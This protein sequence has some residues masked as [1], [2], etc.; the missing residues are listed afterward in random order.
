MTV[1]KKFPAAVLLVAI[2]A[3]AV[4]QQEGDGTQASAKATS[5]A[6]ESG[7]QALEH[8]RRIRNLEKQAEQMELQSEIQRLANEI[9]EANVEGKR[10]GEEPPEAEKESSDE[11]SQSQDR[12]VVYHK[13]PSEQR[14]QQESDGEDDEDAED[15]TSEKEKGVDYRGLDEAAIVRTFRPEGKSERQAMMILRGKSVPVKKDS[16]FGPWQVTAI[17]SGS[18]TV[19]HSEEGE[20]L[21]IGF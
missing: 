9:K 18:I 11:R 6:T 8:E 17:E 14:R 12:Q 5:G 15:E 7:A 10:I 19:K 21:V 2:A 1:S 20:E 4:A 13:R 3:T 16:S